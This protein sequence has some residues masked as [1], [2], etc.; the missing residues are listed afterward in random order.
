MTF[1]DF[2]AVVGLLT[3]IFTVYDRLIVGRLLTTISTEYPQGYRGRC[4]RCENLSKHDVF[5]RQIRSWPSWISVAGN[6]SLRGV[7]VAA[8]GRRFGAVLT[9]GETRQ[10]PITVAKGELVDEDSNACAGARPLANWQA[11]VRRLTPS[12]RAS[13]EMFNRVGSGTGAAS[14]I[15]S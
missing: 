3:G 10:F 8:I 15:A 2:G 14:A 12:A 13:S 6:D 9:P 5:I 4:L 1:T 11:M 7:I